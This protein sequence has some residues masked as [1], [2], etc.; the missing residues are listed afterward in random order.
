LR[1]CHAGGKPLRKKRDVSHGVPGVLVW[2]REK[3]IT[4]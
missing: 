4:I 2:Y 3:S 1:Q